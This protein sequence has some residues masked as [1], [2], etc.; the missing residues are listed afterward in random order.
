MNVISGPRLDVYLVQ[1]GW[2]RERKSLMDSEHC[3]ALKKHQQSYSFQ[4]QKAFMYLQN[5]RSVRKLL[6]IIITI[7]NLLCHSLIFGRPLWYVCGS[8]NIY[9]V[10]IIWY[11]DV[12][13]HVYLNILIL[14]CMFHLTVLIS[15]EKER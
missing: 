6:Q 9:R 7:I 2:L 14:M 5:F 1:H 4:L 8:L 10:N 11:V 12:Y 13:V 3:N 15:N